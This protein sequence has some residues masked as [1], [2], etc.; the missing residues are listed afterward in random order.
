MSIN[1]PSDSHRDR[2]PWIEEALRYVECYHC[3]AETER[4]TAR[5][6]GEIREPDA[7]FFET[8]DGWLRHL[9]PKCSEARKSDPRVG[10]PKPS[11]DFFVRAKNT[12][13]GVWVVLVMGV[14]GFMLLLR[15]S[16]VI[17][18]PFP[19]ASTQSRPTQRQ[20]D[21][22]TWYRSQFYSEEQRLDF[23]AQLEAEENA[24]RDAERKTRGYDRY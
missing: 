3:G 12:S 23:E 13:G 10:Q 18:L 21:L 6:I 1:R 2:P 19:N 17:S 24:S 20:S 11:A 9:C 16:G 8:A 5:E 4:K 22:D 7:G 14:L 15:V